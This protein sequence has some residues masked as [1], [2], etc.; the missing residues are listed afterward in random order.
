M[1][2]SST[3]KNLHKKILQKLN[4][5]IFKVIQLIEKNKSFISNLT[6]NQTDCKDISEIIRENIIIDQFSFAIDIAFG[7]R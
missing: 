1:R 7:Y 3:F 5:I 2:M 6:K 4:L